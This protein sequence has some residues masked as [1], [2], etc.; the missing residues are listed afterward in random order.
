MIE[1][2]GVILASTADVSETITLPS[3]E[4]ITVTLPGVVRIGSLPAPNNPRHIYD[5]ANV[6]V[7]P[8]RLKASIQSRGRN[9]FNLPQAIRDFA[10]ESEWES[11]D[12][13]GNPTIVRGKN[14]AR[15]SGV[16]AIATNLPPHAWLGDD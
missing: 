3:G 9:R 4:T 13:D 14:H 15:P 6:D 2:R 5:V 11:V 1:K 12:A 10:L 16:T 8:D 7:L